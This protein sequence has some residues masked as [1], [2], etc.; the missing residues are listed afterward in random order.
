MPD[1]ASGAPATFRLEGAGRRFGAIEALRPADLVFADG[2]RV[3][4]VGPS[5]SG[6]TTLLALLNATLTPSGGEVTLLGENIAGMSPGRLRV[7]RSRIAT[8]PQHLG[9]VPNLRVWQ[10]VAT[11]RVGARRFFGTLRDLFFP[12]KAALAEIHELLERVGIEEKLFARTS[13]LSGGQQQRVAI[14]RALYQHPEAILADEPVSNVDPAR[15]ASLVALLTELA[16]ERGLT[17]VMNLHNLD[18]A[19]QHFPRLIGLRAGEVVFD[20]DP[21]KLDD[22]TFASLYNLDE[23]ELLEDG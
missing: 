4:V 12:P 5:G 20:Q 22:D 17:L 19:R 23:D 9:L 13:E 21:Q 11:G 8:I 6:K 16:E 2:D 7:I 15:A 3:A 14:A 10:N 18:L 1:S